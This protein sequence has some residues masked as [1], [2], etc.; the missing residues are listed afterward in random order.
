MKCVLGLRRSGAVG[1]EWERPS[2]CREPQQ[3]PP[4]GT[5][6]AAIDD[7]DDD[8]EFANLYRSYIDLW[9][10]LVFQ[11]NCEVLDCDV[12]SLSLRCVWY[13]RAHHNHQI[14]EQ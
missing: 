6:P 12:L 11:Y 8:D 3:A 4:A 1:G 9:N 10:L 13:R 7:D 5:V 2:F 14:V